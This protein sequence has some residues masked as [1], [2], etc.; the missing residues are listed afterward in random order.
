LRCTIG[1]VAFHPA[2]EKCPDFLTLH[3]QFKRYFQAA[4]GWMDRPQILV[5]RA[6][7]AICTCRRKLLLLELNRIRALRAGVPHLGESGL[8]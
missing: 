5:S 2:T 6:A 1:P 3:G 7:T 4:A 8:L